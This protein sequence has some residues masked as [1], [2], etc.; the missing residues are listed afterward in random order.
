VRSGVGI[1]SE[2]LARFFCFWDLGS[3]FA[4]FSFCFVFG[5]ANASNVI[6]ASLD[7]ILENCLSETIKTNNYI[8]SRA[9]DYA[10]EKGLVKA[11]VI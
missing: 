2:F 8:H 10:D 7:A 6:H 3:L 1:R 11:V 5:L 4:S 9:K